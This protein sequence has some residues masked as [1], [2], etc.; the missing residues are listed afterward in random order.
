MKGVFLGLFSTLIFVKIF[1]MEEISETVKCW[2]QLEV[3]ESK[4]NLM[5]VLRCT[6]FVV[7][8]FNKLH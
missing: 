2:L 6:F 5:L 3:I 1:Y 8:V 4:T 7:V